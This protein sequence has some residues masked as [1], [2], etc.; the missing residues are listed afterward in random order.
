ML[1]LPVGWVS[2]IIQARLVCWC[3]HRLCSSV[4]AVGVH[5]CV[6]SRGSIQ[7]CV[8]CRGGEQ[9]HVR[10]TVSLSTFMGAM[11]LS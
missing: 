8:E 2:L 7:I 5:K 9:E 10:L 1:G 11:H 6:V 3:V 4:S